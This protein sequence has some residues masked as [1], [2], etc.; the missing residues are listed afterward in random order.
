[1]RAPPPPLE[2]L[3]PPRYELALPMLRDGELMLELLNE[4]VLERL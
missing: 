4:G 1:M 2:K 3:P